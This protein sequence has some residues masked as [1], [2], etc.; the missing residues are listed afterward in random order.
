MRSA[1]VVAVLLLALVTPTLAQTQMTESVISAAGPEMNGSH[2]LRGT[3]AQSAAG[4]TVGLNY[5]LAIGYWRSYGETISAVPLLPGYLWDLEGNHPNPF[6]PRTTISYS[7]PE[8]GAVSLQV[9]NLRGELVKTLVDEVVAAG[10]H[11]AV[12]NGRDNGGAGVASGVYFARLASNQGVL[13]RKMVL[14]R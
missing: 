4:R 8:A 13:T 7:M 10:D 6:N 3:L 11:E 9:F 14:T 1:F 5:T 12:W 2:R